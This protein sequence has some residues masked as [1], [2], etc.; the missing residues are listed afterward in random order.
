LKCRHCIATIL[1]NRSIDRSINGSWDTWTRET[2]GPP[3]RIIKKQTSPREPR[4][5]LD[6]HQPHIHLR[7]SPFQPCLTARSRIS[8]APKWSLSRS[9]ATT[10]LGAEE[11]I[12]TKP[13]RL[14]N[15]C[16]GEE[17]EIEF[18]ASASCRQNH[19][20]ASQGRPSS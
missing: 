8:Q 10:E 12:R 6:H 1:G 9:A 2:Q 7:R 16:N 14:T 4:P 11:A 17:A 13:E 3:V 18:D 19:G 5:K 15:T 20:S